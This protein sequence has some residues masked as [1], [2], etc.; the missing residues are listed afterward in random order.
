MRECVTRSRK[1]RNISL[2][3]HRFKCAHHII[4]SRLEAILFVKLGQRLAA[5]PKS[6]D[7]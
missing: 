5:P 3:A 2:K 7:C 1:M 6:L 4:E